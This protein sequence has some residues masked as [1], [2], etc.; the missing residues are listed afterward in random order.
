MIKKIVL[1]PILLVF[2]LTSVAAQDVTQEGTVRE[3]V[4]GAQDFFSRLR[5]QFSLNLAVFADALRYDERIFDHEGYRQSAAQ[6]S[7]S[8]WTGPFSGMVGRP[9]IPGMEDRR[10][11]EETSL[12]IGFATDSFGGSWTLRTAA[13]GGIEDVIFGRIHAWVRFGGD[14]TFVRILAGTDNDFEFVDT[15]GGDVGVFLG[16]TGGAAADPL[17]FENGTWRQFRSPDNIT[18]GVGGLALLPAGSLALNAVWRNMLHLDFAAGGYSAVPE[19]RSVPGA[20]NEFFQV[21]SLHFQ[22][23]GRLGWVDPNGFFRA[24]I[25]Y[26]VNFDRT[27]ANFAMQAGT[28]YIIPMAP[29]AERFDHGLGAYVTVF[30]FENFGVTV[31]YSA[32][33]NQVLPSSVVGGFWVDTVHPLTWKHGVSINAR[34]NGLLNGALRLRTDNNLTF[35]HD[36]NY[37]AFDVGA[38]WSTNWNPTTSVSALLYPYVRHLF[39]RNR[40]VVEYDVPLRLREGRRFMVQFDARN[41][42]RDTFANSEQD[43]DLPLRFVRNELFLEGRGQ[44]FFADSV[45]VFAGLRFQRLTVS[46]SEGMTAQMPPGLFWPGDGPMELNDSAIRV[47]VPIGILLSW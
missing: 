2:F 37:G 34:Y 10:T 40:V 20:P 46:R 18:S 25:S 16:T 17:S 21:E 33:I 29:T 6:Q 38:A 15:L 41:M 27:A 8:W 9:L 39:A 23:G 31:G 11:D 5:P 28:R 12:S 13:V 36:K 24:N 30:P 32:V 14:H 26:V 4:Q 43:A 44:Y 1:L 19:V 47:S 42:F 35:F 7:R 22:F 45:S 3:I